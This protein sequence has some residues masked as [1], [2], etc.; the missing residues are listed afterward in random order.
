MTGIYLSIKYTLV[1]DKKESKLWAAW[2]IN[3][4]VGL[5]DQSTKG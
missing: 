1:V 3:T 5:T 2:I 4:C